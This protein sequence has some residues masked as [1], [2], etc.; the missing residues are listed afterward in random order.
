MVLCDLYSQPRP[1]SSLTSVSWSPARAPAAGWSGSWADRR[2]PSWCSSRSSAAAP[3]W[4]A[5]LLHTAQSGSGSWH[6]QTQKNE[7]SPEGHLSPSLRISSEG[8][9][10]INTSNRKS[11]LNY[12]WCTSQPG[13]A[14]SART[15]SVRSTGR[16][17]AEVCPCA[18]SG[19]PTWPS[20]APAC[21]PWMKRSEE[22]KEN[23]Q[24]NKSQ[25][26][27]RII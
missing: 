17:T 6:L 19:C 22:T 11:G 4:R 7:T 8:S 10:K 24:K 26:H 23:R 12:A 1:R 13:R 2:H 27:Q 18:T 21:C 14:N 25:S 20:Q 9:N 3:R 16:S 5:G 15:H